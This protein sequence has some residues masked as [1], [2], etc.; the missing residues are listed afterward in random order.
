MCA[1]LPPPTPLQ[2]QHA[3]H[4]AQHGR[5]DL[6]EALRSCLLLLQVGRTGGRAN[7]CAW[8]VCVGGGMG[9]L[10]VRGEAKGV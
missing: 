7:E 3:L 10:R 8:R 5:V 6:E 9:G 4:Q 2:V 1:V